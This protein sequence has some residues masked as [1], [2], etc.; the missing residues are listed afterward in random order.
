VTGFNPLPHTFPN[1]EAVTVVTL[2]AGDYNVT[3]TALPSVGTDLVT[4][5]D[6]IFGPNP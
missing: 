5:G 1:S 6:N 2:G 3:D 4:L